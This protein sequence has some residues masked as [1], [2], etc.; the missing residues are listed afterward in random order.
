MLNEGGLKEGGV[1]G[2][3]DEGRWGE[4]EGTAF[5]ECKYNQRT[6]LKPQFW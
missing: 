6:L 2:R 1:E 5:S 3:R 4:L